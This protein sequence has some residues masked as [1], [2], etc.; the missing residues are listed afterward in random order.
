VGQ[1]HWP[2]YS[3]TCKLK[4]MKAVVILIRRTGQNRSALHEHCA[5]CGHAV[6]QL[7]RLKGK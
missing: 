7:Q 4:N 2:D 3:L 6:M 1:R 5:S